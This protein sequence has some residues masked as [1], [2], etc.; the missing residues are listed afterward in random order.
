MTPRL[1]VSPGDLLKHYKGGQYVV[2]AVCHNEAN[3]NEMLVSYLSLSDGKP[4]VREL[5]QFNEMII[6]EDTE[7]YGPDP[8]IR[9]EVVGKTK[10]L[11]NA[12]APYGEFAVLGS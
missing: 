6:P 7:K 12:G 3:Q 10:V 5:S 9:F 11:V 8:V 2:L 1:Y 4:W